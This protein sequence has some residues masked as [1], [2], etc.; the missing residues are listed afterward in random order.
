MCPGLPGAEGSGDI[1]DSVALSSSS[2]GCL[3]SLSS[4]L[5]HMEATATPLAQPDLSEARF[6]L[7]QPP[8]VQGTGRP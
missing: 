6:L 5:V 3:R 4:E 7:V 8:P 2:A 1:C